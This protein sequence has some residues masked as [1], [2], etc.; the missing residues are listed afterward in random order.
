MVSRRTLIK[1]GTAGVAA[2]VIRAPVQVLGAAFL[3]DGRGLAQALF[4]ERFAEAR[5]FGAAL[6]AR[7]APIRG[8]RGDVAMLWYRDLKA[9]L[10]EDRLPLVGLTDRTALFC[11]EELARDLGMKVCGRI[12]HSI[13][14][15][16]TV[17]H[18][19]A[20]PTAWL[21]AGQ[22]LGSAPRFGR[23]MAALL[24]DPTVHGS[25]VAAQKRTGPFSALDRT[26]LVSWWIA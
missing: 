20:G 1:L 6:A 10:V 19:A 25:A 17:S 7:G 26:T 5:S 9:R 18:Q 22:R 13:D 4:D 8:I 24:A 2:T 15:L 3:V 14:A 23:T 16:G 12:D 21:D 11:L